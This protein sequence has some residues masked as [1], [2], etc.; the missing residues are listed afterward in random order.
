MGCQGISMEYL[1]CFVDNVILE[2]ALWLLSLC[3]LRA[4][5]PAALSADGS[6]SFVIGRAQKAAQKNPLP[7]GVATGHNW[8]TCAAFSNAAFS[9]ARSPGA[10]KRGCSVP[11]LLAG[12]TENSSVAGC[13][14]TFRILLQ[15]GLRWSL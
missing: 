9:L 8:E 5:I 3:F 13:S 2:P 6:C 1:F 14:V 10:G 4:H 15:L 11:S 12:F 7:T